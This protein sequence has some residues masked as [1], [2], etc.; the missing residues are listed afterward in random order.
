MEDIFLHD[1]PPGREFENAG[2][3]G[4]P[5]LETEVLNLRNRENFQEMRDVYLFLKNLDGFSEALDPF[6]WEGDQ[7]AS[8][9]SDI[10]WR[11]DHLGVK[12]TY[13]NLVDSDMPW[14]LS[15]GLAMGSHGPVEGLKPIGRHIDKQALSSHPFYS[16]SQLVRN[17]FR[18]FHRSDG[19]YERSIDTILAPN[20]YRLS[21]DSLA[22]CRCQL[23]G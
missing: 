16:N 18:C 2:R 23:L 7:N 15:E 10:D 19:T 4:W 21:A 3:S 5:Y 8:L 12:P 6:T 13:W 22:D 1:G 9:H 11:S 17:P 14:Q 20:Q